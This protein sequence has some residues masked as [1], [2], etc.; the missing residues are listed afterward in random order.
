MVWHDYRG[1]FLPIAI[2][3]AT[4]GE[5][6]FYTSFCSSRSF[7]RLRSYSFDV[8]L[9]LQLFAVLGDGERRPSSH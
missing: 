3:I 7:S 1:H 5:H 8:A 6:D 4:R 2:Y 9:K